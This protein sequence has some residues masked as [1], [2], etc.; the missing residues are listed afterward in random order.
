[1][2]AQES[3]LDILERL[4]P[5]RLPSYTI[6][7]DPACPQNPCLLPSTLASSPVATGL[8]FLGQGRDARR[9]IKEHY[10]LVAKRRRL[11]VVIEVKA[12]IPRSQRPEKAEDEDKGGD[13]VK[14]EA[15][16]EGGD[17]AADYERRNWRLEARWLEAQVYVWKGDIEGNEQSWE[18]GEAIEG[19]YDG[20]DRELKIEDMSLNGGKNGEI[21]E[22]AELGNLL[23]DGDSEWAQPGV[24]GGGGGDIDPSSVEW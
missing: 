12:P 5:A 18:L 9:E 23:L 8:L 19:S 4:T 20:G 10:R 14:D 6:V 2:N 1:M 16:G 3:P 24:F 11:K 15:G 22:E 13:E 21:G 7:C 17:D